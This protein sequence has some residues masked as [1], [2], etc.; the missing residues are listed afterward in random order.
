M[1]KIQ[2]STLNTTASQLIEDTINATITDVSIKLEAAE[3]SKQ[4]SKVNTAAG[5]I[6]FSNTMGRIL[7]DYITLKKVIEST[8]SKLTYN[9]F[10]YEYDFKLSLIAGEKKSIIALFNAVMT[11][12]KNSNINHTL[13]SFKQVKKII[14]LENFFDYP[15]TKSDSY[16]KDINRAIITAEE[17]R[18]IALTLKHQTALDAMKQTAKTINDISEIKDI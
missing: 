2:K 14:K 7:S 10:L 15:D 13:I 5:E 18:I 9:S 4:A 6:L 17:K 3:K 8:G 12:L 16:S 1:T 11:A